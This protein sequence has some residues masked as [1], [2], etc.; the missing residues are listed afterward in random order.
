MWRSILLANDLIV[1]NKIICFQAKPAIEEQIMP[2]SF[3]K[4]VCDTVKIMVLFVQSCRIPSY[5]HGAFSQTQ[6]P[7]VRRV[8]A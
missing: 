8:L 1:T 2:T 6:R 3:R 5:F 4:P 7:S